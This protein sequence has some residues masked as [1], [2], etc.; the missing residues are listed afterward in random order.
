MRHCLLRA[1]RLS[2]RDGP[3][4]QTGAKLNVW[5][6]SQ[7]PRLCYSPP[8]KKTCKGAGLDLLLVP[9]TQ[10]IS[11][12]ENILKLTCAHHDVNT[13]LKIHIL[14]LFKNAKGKF[15]VHTPPPPISCFDWLWLAPVGCQI[16]KPNK[17]AGP[18]GNE[19]KKYKE[20]I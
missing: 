18:H 9:A 3:F 16:S 14:F 13:K 10:P 11:R 4:G 19:R 5:N 15:I 2:A 17:G 1:D 8:P 6:K 7:Y 12:R 20:D